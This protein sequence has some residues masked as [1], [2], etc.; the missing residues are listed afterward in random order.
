MVAT[1][2]FMVMSCN[3]RPGADHKGPGTKGTECATWWLL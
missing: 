2:Q 3:A 1:S